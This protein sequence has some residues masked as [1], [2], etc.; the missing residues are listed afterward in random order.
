MFDTTYMIGLQFGTLFGEIH[1]F[2]VKL[3][4]EFRVGAHQGRIVFLQ[5]VQL[6][7]ESTRLFDGLQIMTLFKNHVWTKSKRVLNPFF[8]FCSLA[9]SSRNCF[10]FEAR[11]DSSWF[12]MSC[13][14]ASSSDNFWRKLDAI[15]TALASSS[16]HTKNCCGKN[17][18]N[19]SLFLLY[20]YTRSLHKML[21][22]RLLFNI[23]VK[24]KMRKKT[25]FL[26]SR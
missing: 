24:T 7:L 2:V 8:T 26:P 22:G 18:Q 11:S 1:V 3:F 6:L 23:F 15:V 14:I 25:Q 12:N 19:Y 4:A 21:P 10:D 16:W 5:T 20:C 13:L 9:C 17:S